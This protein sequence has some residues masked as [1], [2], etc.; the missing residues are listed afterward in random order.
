M[1]AHRRFCSSLLPLAIA[2]TMLGAEEPAP[3]VAA[4][5]SN[6]PVTVAD[7]GRT[8]VLD[9]GIVQAT[10]NKNNGNLVVPRSFTASIRWAR[11]DTGSKPREGAPR[12]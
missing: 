4:P 3:H 1:P 8:W 6:A 5:E 2:G 10:I 7:S 11:A 12:N 9:N